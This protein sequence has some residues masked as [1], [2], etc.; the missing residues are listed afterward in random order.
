MVDTPSMLKMF[1]RI[2]HQ[3]LRDRTNLLKKERRTLA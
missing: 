1:D 3:R 2:L